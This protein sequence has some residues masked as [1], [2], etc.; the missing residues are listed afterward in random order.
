VHGK[1]DSLCKVYGL[2]MNSVFV[3][4]EGNSYDGT[5]FVGAENEGSK[6]GQA[7]RKRDGFQL[8]AFTI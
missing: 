1:N 7:R 3:I 5:S 2:I 4:P 8:R 6:H